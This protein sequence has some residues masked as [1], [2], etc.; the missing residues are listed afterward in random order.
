MKNILIYG[1]GRM[2][3]THYAILNSLIPNSKFTFVE[4]NY[5]VNYLLRNNINASFYSD[6][7]FDDNFDLSLITTPPFA[8]THILDKCLQRGDKKIFVEKPFGG[9]ENHK[10]S[11]DYRNVFIGYVLRFNPIINWIKNN[12]DTDNIYEIKAKYLS[13]TITSKPTGWRNGNF[14]GVLNEMGSHIIDTLNYLFN[15]SDFEVLH[16]DL[17]SEISD[18]DDIVNTKI[19]SSNKKIS[20]DL[21]WVDKTKRKPVFDFEITMKKNE[22]IKFDQQKIYFIK[23]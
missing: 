21:N 10:S 15:L 13:N 7:N 23:K 4:P 9:Y 20:I 1:F 16:S 8:H 22:K 11:L 2:G 14:S 6:D 5:K 3:L 17:I 19:I 18:L 12:I